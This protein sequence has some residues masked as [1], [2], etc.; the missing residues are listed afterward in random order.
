MGINCGNLVLLKAYADNCGGAAPLGHLL[1]FGRLHSTLSPAEQHRMARR[2]VIAPE[3]L[4]DRQTEGLLRRIG[5]TEVL[6]LDVSDY[7]GCDIVFDLTQDL[8]RRADL[9]PRLLSRF[10]T[11]LDYGTSEHVFN[12]GQ[13]L[14]NAWNMLNETGAYIFDLPVTGWASHGLYQFSPNFFHSLGQTGFFKLEHLFFHD[15]RGDRIF[16]VPSFDAAAYRRLNGARKISAWG[17]LRK[18]RPA[19]MQGAL[20]LEDFRVM[21]ADIRLANPSSAARNRTYR[22][23]TIAAG[24]EPE[25]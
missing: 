23:A 9:G 5:S 21:Q 12:V 11:V 4:A 8:A 7:E 18:V 16:S 20:R 10:D 6:S 3:L 22:M 14:V 15:K 13:A 19:A 2:H 25:T 17:V 24:F 1:M